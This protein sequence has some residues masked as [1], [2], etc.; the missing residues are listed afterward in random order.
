MPGGLPDGG[1]FSN[2]RTY[3]FYRPYDRRVS[4]FGTE[5]IEAARRA[6]GYY[7]QK[8]DLVEFKPDMS[9]LSHIFGYMMEA[10]GRNG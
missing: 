7:R 6:M 8:F 4:D 2:T 9:T 10:L 1:V 5:Y 3:T